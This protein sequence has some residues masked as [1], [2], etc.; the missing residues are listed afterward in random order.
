M[1]LCDIASV[2]SKMLNTSTWVL[3]HLAMFQKQIYL[4][5]MDS[6][7][8]RHYSWGV[9]AEEIPHRWFCCASKWD[10]LV[11][12]R[13]NQSQE[14]ALPRDWCKH[15][16]TIRKMIVHL[17]SKLRR[18]P[19]T[20]DLITVH[21]AFEIGIITPTVQMGFGKRSR[22][23]QVTWQ[24]CCGVDNQT[25]ISLSLEYMLLTTIHSASLWV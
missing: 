22:L 4:Q 12:Q 2:S 8:R 23:I 13:C 3:G 10:L 9:Q 11:S 19:H 24:I 21:I 15:S 17:A 7:K 16:D 14:G 20:D 6:T 18:H 25:P 5:G 1:R